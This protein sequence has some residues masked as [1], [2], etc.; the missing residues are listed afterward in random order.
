MAQLHSH[1]TRFPS[2]HQR[3]HST[4]SFAMSS[5][6]KEPK[7]R[8]PFYGL[9]QEELTLSNPPSANFSLLNIE[10]LSATSH[11]ATSPAIGRADEGMTQASE[12]PHFFYQSN[13]LKS[14]RS[15][16]CSQGDRQPGDSRACQSTSLHV[17]FV[18]TGAFSLSYP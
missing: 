2:T 13:V 14:H 1:P 10:C 4:A 9:V 7:S 16:F 17:W 5:Q 6:P 3:P 11:I 12:I 8:N 18:L 15:T